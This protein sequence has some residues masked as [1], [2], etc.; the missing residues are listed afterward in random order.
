M[1][2]QSPIRRYA[3][4]MI[5]IALIIV[6]VVLWAMGILDGERITTIVRIVSFLPVL[7][8]G[9][10]LFLSKDDQN[11]KKVLS[12]LMCIGGTAAFALVTRLTPLKGMLNGIFGPDATLLIPGLDREG[13]AVSALLIG[14]IFGV[15]LLAATILSIGKQKKGRK[16]KRR[17]LD[18]L[19]L[20]L[21]AAVL[22][23]LIAVA[24]FLYRGIPVATLVALVLFIVLK[25]IPAEKL[26]SNSATAVALIFAI[27][28]GVM[29]GGT[30]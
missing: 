14:I 30:L 18:Q 17:P 4:I 16:M 9:M 26:S 5:L 21:L 20:A 8:A 25:A 7:L 22:V 28:A 15:G 6:F 12:A 19:I 1:K 29:L 13:R 23:I 10:M 27:C 2:K 24:L 11:G 3:G